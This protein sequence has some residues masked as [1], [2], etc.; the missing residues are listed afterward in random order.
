MNSIVKTGLISLVTAGMLTGVAFASESV[1]SKVSDALVN[2]DNLSI[3]KDGYV[4][5]VVTGLN[6][7]GNVA[8]GIDS[9]TGTT[10][11][12]GKVY[13][14]IE[15]I[16]G[17]KVQLLD[18][19]AVAA[20]GSLSTTSVS[21]NE[22]RIGYVLLKDTN[23]FAIGK[24][25]IQYKDVNLAE[26][27]IVVTIYQYQAG[28]EVVVASVN[29]QVTITDPAT[30][31]NT[32][33]V[34]S[35]KI[36]KKDAVTIGATTNLKV[37]V[38]AYTVYKTADQNLSTKDEN[39]AGTVTITLTPTGVKDDYE[40]LP[41]NSYTFTG[42]MAK[43][44]AN[45]TV[46]STVTEAGKYYVKAELAG[47]DGS[48]VNISGTADELI[49]NPKAVSKKL[50]VFTNKEAVSNDNKSTS[51]LNIKVC[52]L[53]EYG[54]RTPVTANF[55]ANLTDEAGKADFDGNTT[56]AVVSS[57][58]VNIAATKACASDITINNIDINKSGAGFASTGIA[59]FTAFK[60]GTTADYKSDSK[61]VYITD[62]NLIAQKIAVSSVAG[63]KIKLLDVGVD[64]LNL[65]NWDG[66]GGSATDKYLSTTETRSLKVTRMDEN[67]KTLEVFDVSVP[68]A[69]TAIEVTPNK[70][71]T[72]TTEYLLVQDTT[73]EYGDLIVKLSS[74]DVNVT[75]G[76]VSSIKLVN[77]QGGE[78][79]TL[80]ADEVYTGTELTSYTLDVNGGLFKAYDALGNEVTSVTSSAETPK[81]SVT[82]SNNARAFTGTTMGE[83]DVG[84][85]S[86]Y[87]LSY[88]TSD[89]NGPDTL[90]VTSPNYPDVTAPTFTTPLPQ[91][92]K[93][94]AIDIVSEVYRL[95]VNGLLPLS[96][97]FKDAA[98]N[99]VESVSTAT[100]VSY[101][102]TF[103]QKLT[104]INGENTTP[105]TDKEL[106]PNA[107]LGNP[108]ND[109]N[110]VVT[111]QA[112]VKEGNFTLTFKNEDA[113]V[114]GKKI[115]EIY[116]PAA[117][118]GL[119]AEE[120]ATFEADIKEIASAEAVE[121]L[122]EAEK[123]EFYSEAGLAKIKAMKKGNLVIKP[124]ADGKLSWQLFTSPVPT[125]INASQLG[126]LGED[127]VAS[128]TFD[129][130][131]YKYVKNPAKILPM[132]AFWL[133]PLKEITIEID[134]EG[135]LQV[136][137]LRQA[138]ELFKKSEVNYVD[139]KWSMFGTPFDTIRDDVKAATGTNRVYPFDAEKFVYTLKQEMPA[140]TG[141][142]IK[143]VK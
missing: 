136:L 139:G 106:Y 58:K 35:L 32:S 97:V 6:D 5:L 119:T 142:W 86:A 92:G 11:S 62:K 75:A 60:N 143:N 29:K 39:A 41:T 82:S 133:K 124:K 87:N 45:I 63:T 113:E 55:D 117:T 15:S 4:N 115:I 135:A 121:G 27:T 38:S 25:N 18:K 100:K 132:Q 110:A 109:G 111:V 107:T 10:N 48:S 90:T 54:N 122:T 28:K 3:L 42:T 88:L 61:T 140:G 2:A 17:G 116:K 34:K 123:K 95:P 76:A 36:E 137:N 51:S 131:A 26:D 23:N 79:T 89:F 103:E 93:L 64:E 99:Q 40:N 59:K 112:G 78:A 66:V 70:A 24:L 20:D 77:N 68:A 19:S 12:F 128:Y 13:A 22:S 80:T 130:K 85:A 7:T 98:G 33:T 16:G 81:I 50:A 72:T 14:K 94:S 108:D 96:V 47:F 120:V 69:S 114:T 9:T 74:S 105:L 126:V 30:V 125:E 49:V 67:N 53:D 138:G 104:E 102:S 134:A 84:N 37:D 8:S 129:A 1:D 21:N 46:P 31:E 118:D 52:M 73:K 44:D 141:A 127:Y 83:L 71:T 65:S 91:S 43:G 101:D 57:V 56:G